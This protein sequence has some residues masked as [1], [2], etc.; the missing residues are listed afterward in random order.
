MAK[1]EGWVAAVAGLLVVL[2]QVVPSIGGSLNYLWGLVAI[3]FGV[4]AAV[5]K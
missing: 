2:G 4:W 1:W 3:V 5:A